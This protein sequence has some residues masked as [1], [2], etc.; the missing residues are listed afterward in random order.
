ME[1]KIQ[2][3][4]NSVADLYRVDHHDGEVSMCGLGGIEGNI[5]NDEIYADVAYY[6]LKMI[7]KCI[8]IIIFIIQQLVDLMPE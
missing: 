1:L 4:L 7:D 8:H 3:K 6:T 2:Q 5:P